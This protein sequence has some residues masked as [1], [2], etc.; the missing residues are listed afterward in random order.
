MLGY[1]FVEEPRY[2]CHAEAAQHSISASIANWVVHTYGTVLSQGHRVEADHTQR[3]RRYVLFSEDA[4]R[5][6]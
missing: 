2:E 3:P 1:R 6:C 4:S 5:G